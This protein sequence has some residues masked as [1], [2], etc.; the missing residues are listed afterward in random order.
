MY[1]IYNT[2]SGGWLTTVGNY[3]SQVSEARKFSLGNAITHCLAHFEN[4]NGPAYTCFP[5]NVDILTQIQEEA[6]S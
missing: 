6:E 5:V 1:Y 4:Y 2:T 3:S